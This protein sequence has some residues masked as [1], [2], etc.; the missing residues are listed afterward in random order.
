MDGFED[1]TFRPNQEVSRQEAIVTLVRALQLAQTAPASAIGE[2]AQVDLSIYAD[3]NQ[4]AD[5][6]ADAI[7]IAVREGLVNGYGDE[8]RPEKSLT[9]A[10]TTVL[11]Y[12][13]LR[14]AGLIDG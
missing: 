8:L 4:I 3:R 13:M 14:H 10:E 2:G 1:G 9:R 6:A 12:R 5:W 11:I 7:R